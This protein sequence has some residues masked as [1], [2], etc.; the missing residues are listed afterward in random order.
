MCNLRYKVP[1]EIP[2]VLHNGSTYDCHFIIKEL[3]KEF[4][5]NF[6]C[7]GENTE[8]YITFSVP[9][10]K[11]IENK[12]IEI[13]YKIKFIDSYR[14]MSMSL[15]KLIDNLSKGLHNNKC[16]NCKSCLDYIKTKSEKLLFKCFNCKQNYEKDFNKELIKRF[17]ST[18]EFCNKN[19]NKFVLLLRKG[20]YPYEYM[21]N[22]KRFN[23]T[24]LPTKE[25]FYS[26]L[27]MENIEDIDYSYGNNVFK[28]F[29]LKNLVEY[30]DLYVQS[31]TLLL[32][33]VFENFRNTCLKVYELDTAHFLSLP[34][35]AWQACLKKT[36]VKLELLT[37]YDML[38]MVEEGIRGGICHSIHRCAKAN[39]K[40]MKNY[41]ENEK[42]SYIQYLDANNLCRWAISQKLPVNGFKW[43]EDTSEIN[44][45]FIKN[46]DENND[47]G[48]ILEVDVKYPRKLHNLHSDLPFLPKIM[49]IDT[50]KKL[51]CNLH[52]KKNYVVHKAIK[53]SIKSQIKIKKDSHNY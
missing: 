33:D 30:H 37:D 28:R 10:K 51:V 27:N 20:V 47:K 15:S 11:K 50:C 41:D 39:N 13:T 46:Y 26:N 16:L 17:T 9:I 18:Y 38:L 32:A 7:L 25:S 40:Y 1:K 43:L 24:S 3:V 14:F 35:L 2:I 52:N 45:E 22:W 8:K 34:G 42:S 48:Y 19:L 21:D 44:E 29:K 6:E 36:N 53:T 49:K 31:D 4:D 5:G 23:E 12:N